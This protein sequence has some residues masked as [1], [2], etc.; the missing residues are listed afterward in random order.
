MR[1]RRSCKLCQE[2]LQGRS[3]QKFCSNECR[4]IFHN[5]KKREELQTVRTVNYYLLNNRAILARMEKIQISE[6]SLLHPHLVGFSPEFCTGAL[7]NGWKACYEYAFR[8]QDGKIVIKRK[9]KLIQHQWGV[10]DAT[11]SL[12][13]D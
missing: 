2:K 5:Q 9:Q 4:S 3:D 7:P 12:V 11:G 13:A 1:E 8:L 10:D 6:C